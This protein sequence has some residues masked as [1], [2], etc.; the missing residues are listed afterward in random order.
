VGALPA[1]ACGLQRLRPELTRLW[2]VEA[3]QRAR[4]DERGRGSR[5]AEW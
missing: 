2:W 3:Q 1:R 5:R 4:L